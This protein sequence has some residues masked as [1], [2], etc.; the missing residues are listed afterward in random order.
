MFGG[1]SRVNRNKKALVSASHECFSV[2][3]FPARC[4]NAAHSQ[5][6]GSKISS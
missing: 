4:I 6:A 1:E 3:Y 2:L 5:K